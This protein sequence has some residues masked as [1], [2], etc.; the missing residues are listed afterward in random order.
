MGNPTG[1]EITKKIMFNSA[2]HEILNAHK[3][4]NIKKFSILQA[5]MSIEYYFSAHKLIN[6]N[7]HE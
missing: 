3:Y 2:E 7:Q 4:K 5:Q 6:I 1:P